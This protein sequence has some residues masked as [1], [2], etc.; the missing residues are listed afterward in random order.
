MSFALTVV[1]LARVLLIALAVLVVVFA[2][3]RRLGIRRRRP[4]P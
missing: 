1:K 2:V 4:G 3:N